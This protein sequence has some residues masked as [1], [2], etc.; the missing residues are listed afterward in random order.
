MVPA[1]RLAITTQDRLCTSPKVVAIEGRAVATMV[2]SAAD[3]KTGR[4]IGG[5]TSWNRPRFGGGTCGACCSAVGDVIVPGVSLVVPR[6]PSCHTPLGHTTAPRT[7][8]GCVAS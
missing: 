7:H 1:I 5:T 3:R 4:M 2:P 6:H 8:L